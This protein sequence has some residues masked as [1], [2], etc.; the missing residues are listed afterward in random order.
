MDHDII[1]VNFSL[2]AWLLSGQ[3]RICQQ[4]RCLPVKRLCLDHR[5]EIIWCEKI[6]LSPCTPLQDLCGQGSPKSKVSTRLLNA[7]TKKFINFHLRDSTIV[8]DVTM[9]GERV[10]NIAQL[11]LLCILCKFY[12]ENVN[13]LEGI[14]ALSGAK[15]T[16]CQLPFLHWSTFLMFVIKEGHKKSF[17]VFQYFHLGISITTWK[18]ESEALYG[19]SWNGEIGP[20]ASFRKTYGKIGLN[21]F[22]VSFESA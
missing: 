7:K 10:G 12:N 17:F 22:C 1:L 20:E 16:W 13:Y 3:S 6:K 11:A 18:V 4:G 2:T 15:G 8:P 21:L 14:P 19:M 9:V 5:E